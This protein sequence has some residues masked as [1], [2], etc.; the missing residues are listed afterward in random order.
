MKHYLARMF[1]SFNSLSIMTHLCF[2]L[3]I[4]YLLWLI[5]VL[6]F[7][8]LIFRK[9]GDAS[10]HVLFFQ[11]LKKKNLS[12]KENVLFFRPSRNILNHWYTGG[13]F[14]KRLMTHKLWEI[15]MCF[16]IIPIRHLSIHSI[17]LNIFG[18]MVIRHFRAIQPRK[19]LINM[20]P[21]NWMD[22]QMSYRD[23]F[24]TNKIYLTRKVPYKRTV[25]RQQCR[26]ETLPDW[27]RTKKNFGPTRS[28]DPCRTW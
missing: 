17:Y 18:I 1:Y 15:F 25:C 28:M 16:W 23:D 13:P 20:I 5:C 10:K 7:Q 19:C 22:W 2:I 4:S 26:F 3:S 12:H 6:F 24:E 14:H 27:N 11:F 21:R 8:F 9:S